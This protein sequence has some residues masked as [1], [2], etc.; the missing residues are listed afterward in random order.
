MLNPTSVAGTVPP[1]D[2]DY[3]GF[4]VPDRTLIVGFVY[5]FDYVEQLFMS[6]VYTPRRRKFASHRHIH[7]CLGSTRHHATRRRQ[8]PQD[9]HRFLGH[10]PTVPF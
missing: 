3:M 5:Q 8:T 4:G 9:D 6:T 1:L 7:D 10:L 2:G